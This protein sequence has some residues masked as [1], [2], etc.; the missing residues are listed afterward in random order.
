[1]ALSKKITAQIKEILEQNPQGLSITGIVNGVKINRN[2]AGRYLEGL[3]A[4]GQVEMRRLGMAKIYT[5]SHRVPHSAVLSISSDLIMQLDSHLRIIYINNPFIKFLGAT[6][7]DLVGKN[8]EYSLL[9]TALENFFEPF[10]EHVR[11]GINGVEW[12]GEF[13]TSKPG[14][15][16]ACRVTPS[17]FE[18]GQKGVSVIFEDITERKR[19]EE[20]LIE[21]ERQYRDIFENAVLGIFR[22]TPEGRFTTINPTF[23]RISGYETPEKMIEAIRDVRNQLYVDPADRTLFMNMLVTDGFVKGHEARFYHKDGHIVWISLNAIAVRNQEGKVLYFE[24]TIEDITERKLAEEALRK[25]EA[26]LK[27]AEEVGRSG[28]WELW[29]NENEVHASEGAYILYGLGESQLT[30]EDIQKFPLPEYRPLLDT[31]L[32]DLIAGKSPYNVEFKI[33]RR[34]DGAILDIH[35]IAEYDPEKNVVFGTIHDV[36]ERKQV[37]EALATVN[38]RLKLLTCTVRHDINNQLSVLQSYLVILERE[39]NGLRDNE[40]FRRIATIVQRISEIIRFTKEYEAIGLNAPVWQDCYT[41]V[42][43]VR[44]QAPLGQV[45]VKNDIPSCIELFADPL[46]VKV[47]YNLLDNAVRHGRKT[48]YIR[49]SV[50]EHNGTFVILCEDNGDGI[51]LELKEKIFDRGFGKNTGLGL[52]LA[53]EILSI[54]G[55]TIQETGI[56]GNNAR[57]EIAVPRGGFRY[58]QS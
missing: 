54:T 7:R 35:S 49:F 56:P 51:P 18:N 27:R 14:I 38:R 24:G 41:I 58:T 37:T 46:I 11:N 31:A 8:M 53:R 26:D 34:S 28:S 15:I 3:L 9:V 36:S 44:K 2:T 43:T 52:F 6:Q 33:Q 29:L 55:I 13:S 32:K 40:Y 47:F 57:F 20:T 42:D 19:A 10:R 4:S 45:M 21:S 5:L 48:T 23:A 25:S 30:I 1:M 16:F 39:S 50:K 12:R 17:V 22:T